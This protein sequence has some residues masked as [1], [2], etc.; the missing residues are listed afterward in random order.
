MDFFDYLATNCTNDSLRVFKQWSG[1]R[2][3]NEDELA[4]GLR[5]LVGQSHDVQ[6]QEI[7]TQLAEIHP[8]RKMI[9]EVS[10]LSEEIQPTNGHDCNCPNCQIKYG[11]NG[12]NAVAHF[13]STGEIKNLLDN[14]TQTLNQ[15]LNNLKQE[16][17]TNHKM[18]DK[19]FKLVMLGVAVWL[20]FKITKK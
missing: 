14:K 10:G 17:T 15:E 1:I 11:A 7:L 2:V 6:K 3:T 5:S 4:D 20:I 13:M 16:S 12:Q 19:I 8:D 18:N 9:T